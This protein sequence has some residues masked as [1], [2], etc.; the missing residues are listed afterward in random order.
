[1]E[2]NSWTQ[3]CAALLALLL[4][5]AL[6]QEK[7]KPAPK[8]FTAEE[9]EQIVSPIALHPDE[10]LSQ[11]LMASTYPMEV[12]E[13]HR[14]VVA[15]PK[16]KG[17]EAAKALEK[18]IWDP[19]VKSLVAFPEVLK[20]MD[21]QLEWMRKLGDAFISQQKEVMEAIQRLRKKAMDEG[22]LKSSDQ[23]KVSEEGGTIVVES[24]DPDVVYV[25]VY[26]TKVVYGS[27]PYPAYP[28]YYWYPPTP[29]P[30]YYGAG[31][32][33]GFAW[34]YAWGHCDWDDCDVDVDI[35][36][37]VDRN[38]NINRDQYRD[39]M[40]KSGV[41]G[42]RGTWQHNPTHRRGVSYRDQ[43]T[44][45]RYNKGKSPAAASREAFRGRSSSATQRPSAGTRP[46]SKPAQRP[47]ARP[48]SASRSNGFSGYSQGSQARQQSSRGHASRQSYSRSSGGSRGGGASRGGG[49][50]RGGG[51][52]GRRR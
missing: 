29:T 32:A 7:E 8:P 48:S 40:Q 10:L 21:E 52:G 33:I 47:A 24:T 26:D 49:G 43:A 20:M 27:W 37:N 3:R 34:G 50:A 30:Y 13:C 51:G 12:V 17:D 22:H 31:I 28:P 9:L 19:S 16:L 39:R 36:R 35:D 44:A 6:G 45:Q 23:Q 25:P 18:K 1:M 2:R 41:Q 46:A 15:N 5:P 4:L 42:G 14:W 38:R 11:I